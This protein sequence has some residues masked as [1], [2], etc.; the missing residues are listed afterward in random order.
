MQKL[1]GNCHRLFRKAFRVLL[2]AML[3]LTFQACPDYGAP[4]VPEYGVPTC[5]YGVPSVLEN[6]EFTDK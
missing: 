5:M 4:D 3:G 2:I 1:L 6:T